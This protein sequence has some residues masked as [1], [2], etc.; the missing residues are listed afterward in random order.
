MSSD[1]LTFERGEGGSS[2]IDLRGVVEA[3][4]QRIM[5][6]PRPELAEPLFW[7]EVFAIGPFQEGAQVVAPGQG[8]LL[9][10][11]LLP[12]RIIQVGESAKIFTV[13]VLNPDFPDPS[14]SACDIVTGFGAKIEL[15][16]FTSD[17]QRMVSVPALS[18]TKTIQTVRNVCFYVDEFEFTPQEPACLYETNICARI[19]NCKDAPIQPFGAF[20]RWIIDLDSDQI[21]GSE[22]L[23]FDRPVRYMVTDLESPCAP[24]E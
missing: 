1:E 2:G 16:Y 20:V 3:K 10:Q 12:H 23:E 22:V 13:V 11:P 7:W 18:A 9:D 8:D 14:L 5:E 6:S 17:T 21:F 4:M 24:V 15:N 19:C